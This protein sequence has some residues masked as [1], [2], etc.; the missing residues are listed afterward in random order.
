MDIKDLQLAIQIWHKLSQ[1]NDLGDAD[2]NKIYNSEITNARILAVFKELSKQ[3]P[4]FKGLEF[5]GFSNDDLIKA[6]RQAQNKNNLEFPENIVFSKYFMGV[7]EYFLG[8]KDGGELY[9]PFASDFSFATNTNI[10][11]FCDGKIS[12]M[13]AKALEILNNIKIDFRQGDT[14]E[15]PLFREPAHKL[16]EFENVLA[17]LFMPFSQNKHIDKNE[18]LFKL[19]IAAQDSNNELL[20]RLDYILQSFKNKALIVLPTG[21]GFRGKADIFRK[22]IVDSNLLETIISLP[23]GFWRGSGMMVQTQIFVLNKNKQN[24]DVAIISLDENRSLNSPSKSAAF[25][26]FITIDTGKSDIN[27]AR[28]E[29]LKISDLKNND[30]SLIADSYFNKN[31]VESIKTAFHGLEY[32]KL[33]NIAH[34]VRSQ[35]FREYEVGKKIKEISH[36]DFPDAGFLDLSKITRSKQIG[37]QEKKLKNYRVEPFDILLNARGTI[38]LSTI[39]PDFNEGDMDRFG[40]FAFVPSQTI[41]IIR[42]K[43]QN[44]DDKRRLAV[45]LL[46]FLRSV[47]GQKLIKGIS[48]GTLME[49]II[50][51]KLKELEAPR[52]TQT[53]IQKLNDNFEAE[54]K[55]YKEITKIKEQLERLH[56]DFLGYQG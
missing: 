32:T 2:F 54:I 35:A 44:A 1:N 8:I 24:D 14:L 29:I 47:L 39:V 56:K 26:S 55:L 41:Q 15:N 16:K 40:C 18:N 37:D 13:E 53:Q 17:A 48:S 27:F 36:A 5:Q 9:V 50:T 52:F 12:K 46:M 10:S 49:Q 7:A 4:Y 25:Y 11:Y 38:G 51:K 34:L 6:M 23:M 33:E 20:L 22:K 21:F 28:K 45:A 19:E 42:V 43:A 31:D 30:Y 3:Y